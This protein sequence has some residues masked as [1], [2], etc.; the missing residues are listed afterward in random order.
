MGIFDK[1][2]GGD[3]REEEPTCGTRGFVHGAVKN[4]R[5]GQSPSKEE[6][7]RMIKDSNK[8]K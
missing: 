5:N 6:V 7:D 2:F 4:L 8:K 3:K 1:V